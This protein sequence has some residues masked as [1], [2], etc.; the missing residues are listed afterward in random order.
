MSTRVAGLIH[1]RRQLIGLL[2]AHH[3]VLPSERAGI[4]WDWLEGMLPARA[5]PQGFRAAWNLPLSSGRVAVSRVV[6]IR[7]LGLIEPWGVLTIVLER[8]QYDWFIARSWAALC[9]ESFWTL[10]R[11]RA[12]EGVMLPDWPSQAVP[13]MDQV[14]AARELA[15]R[16]QLRSPATVSSADPDQ[17]D[18]QVLRVP[19]AV[20]GD[21]RYRLRWALGLPQPVP[22]AL[23]ATVR[24]VRA[25]AAPQARTDFK[26]H[27][28]AADSEAW[29][30]PPAHVPNGVM[31]DDPEF[32][33][34]VGPSGPAFPSSG[35]P[36]EAFTLERKHRSGGQWLV[37]AICGGLLLAGVAFAFWLMTR[38]GA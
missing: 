32:G 12:A 8:P 34:D 30:Q 16:G 27:A 14:H 21:S 13:S 37:P 9:D 3:G 31:G 6:P 26:A 10:P 25:V 22:G 29:Q 1:V 19:Q 24:A 4:S 15:H 11:F 20:T 28:S 33:V 35:D 5:L 38:P 18:Q 7:E 36:E 17:D 23:V 2:H